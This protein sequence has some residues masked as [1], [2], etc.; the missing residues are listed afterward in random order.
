MEQIEKLL[1]Y[2]KKQ[3]KAAI[4]KSKLAAL[5]DW[6]AIEVLYS[7]GLRIS[8]LTNL[9][10][11]NFNFEAATLRIMGKGSKERMVPVG[12]KAI[13]AV[14]S[15]LQAK[16]RPD[17]FYLFSNSRGKPL[18]R[19]IM[20][21]RVSRLGRL[22]LDIRITPHQLRHSFATHLLTAGLDLKSLQEMLGH[23]SLEATQI[24]T[25]LTTQNLQKVYARTH[26][27]A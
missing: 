26:P 3:A 17:C 7:S 6:A 12:Q 5:R 19:V 4:I 20:E 10:R 8:E 11:F 15:Y 18:S 22:A 21:R 27:R 16:N 2:A 25:A 24:Y 1:D 13:E 14:N 23:R 9:S